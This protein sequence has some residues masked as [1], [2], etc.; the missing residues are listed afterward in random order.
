MQKSHSWSVRT[1]RTFKRC[2]TV[3]ILKSCRGIFT[4]FYEQILFWRKFY[5]H[6]VT[7]ASACETNWSSFEYIYSKRRNKLSTAKAEKLVYV[8]SNLKLFN[9]I[10]ES[11]ATSLGDTDSKVD[12]TYCIDFLDKVEKWFSCLLILQL[13]NLYHL[14]KHK[15]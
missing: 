10:S 9:Q 2:R 12:V 3:R 11:D 15:T 5:T 6:Q 13:Y 7:S 1:V 4:K 8:H 14:S